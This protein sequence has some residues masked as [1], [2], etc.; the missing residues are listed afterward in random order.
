[1]LHLALVTLDESEHP[2]T[3]H[4]LGSATE[5]LTGTSQSAWS[6]LI[7]VR[8]SCARIELLSAIEAIVRTWLGRDPIHLIGCL[9]A[10]ERQ[11]CPR[12]GGG[13]PFRCEPDALRAR[14]SG[15]HPAVVEFVAVSINTNSRNG[16]RWSWWL[17][18][19]GDFALG[20]G[21]PPV[22]GRPCAPPHE[23]RQVLDAHR[24]GRARVPRGGPRVHGG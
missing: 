7:H 16:Q 6:S 5:A 3:D 11:A 1:M 18:E 19:E 20:E 9:T 23:A 21:W 4:A 22:P 14:T 13:A 8:I 10:L 24:R 2:D 17:Q 12:E 15:V